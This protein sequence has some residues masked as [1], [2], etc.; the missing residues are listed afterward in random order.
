VR[1]TAAAV[2]MFLCLMP[3][4]AWAFDW[5]LRSTASE[6]AE[7]NDNLFLNPKPVGGT[8]GSYSTFTAN[9]EARTATS[10]FDLDSSVNYSKFLGP[11][12]SVLPENQNLSYGF[13]G[14]YET[15]DKNS[16]DRNFIE[17]SFNQSSTA[18]ALLNQLGVITNTAGTLNTLNFGGGLDRSLSALDT[19]SLFA[20]STITNND[21]ASAGTAFTDTSASGSW[22]HRLG[23]LTTITASSEAERLDFDN[24]FGT[25]ILIL[26]NQGGFNTSLSPLLSFR[27]TWGA[28][29]VQTDNSGPGAIQTSNTGFITDML[30]TYRALK[31]TTFTLAGFQTVG[32]TALGSL[33][34]SSALRATV[35]QFINADSSLSFSAD[36]DQNS[37]TSTTEF[38]SA[39]VSYNYRLAREWTAN[40]SYRY[41]HSFGT[42]GLAAFAT[43]PGTP[44]IPTIG[45]VSSNSL[46]VVISK[47]TTVLPHTD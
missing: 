18:F 34:K 47:S 39:S 8:L 40:L 33:I 29:Y 9:A 20:R 1:T 46:V 28:A 42:T 21:P 16:S 35:T 17:A 32:P 27:G 36:A 30:L 45:A 25:N 38:A 41:I 4:A 26:R 5:S 6:T 19:I 44:I 11:G 24:A 12:A 23:S 13:K 37:S 14:H 43:V 31:N 2:S 10:K 15:T 7:L 3:P 22:S